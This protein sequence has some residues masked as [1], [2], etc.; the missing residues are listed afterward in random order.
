MGLPRLPSVSGRV[1][2]ILP[3]KLRFLT[4]QKPQKAEQ[5]PAQP[6]QLEGV[7]SHHADTCLYLF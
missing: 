6:Y 4:S 5:S 1:M 2:C 3:Q 7:I